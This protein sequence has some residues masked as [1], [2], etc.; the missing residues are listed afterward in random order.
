MFI[1]RTDHLRTQVYDVLRRERVLILAAIDVDSA[2]ACKIFQN[3]LCCDG[4]Q[5]SLVPVSGRQSLK[6]A[7]QEHAGQARHVVL[8]NC[9]ATISVVD[10]LDANDETHFYIFDS[11]RPFDLYNV[12]SD[13][14]HL[15]KLPDEDLDFPQPEEVFSDPE[16]E[17][18]DS[19]GEV[20]DTYEDSLEPE[21]D[22][23]GEPSAKRRAFTMKRKAQR[24]R[25]KRVWEQ[26]RA[27]ILFKYFEFYYHSSATSLIMLELAHFMSKDNNDLVWW[28]I[29]GLTE[30]LLYQRID[31]EKYV[32]DAAQLQ[33][34]FVLRLNN[35]SVSSVH[36][37]RIQFDQEL[38]LALYRH[39]SMYE[40]LLHSE[41][42]S[43]NFKVWTQHGQK[44]LHEFLANMG[45]P[46]VQ[47]KQKFGAMD[48]D[49]RNNVKTWMEELSPKYRLDDMTYGS[50]VAQ[51]G[52]QHKFSA[53]DVV[54]ALT[55]LLENT[56]GQMD[57]STNFFKA[58]DALSRTNSDVLR[59]GIALGLEHQLA[60]SQQV[61]LFMDMKQIVSAGSFTY[62]YIDESSPHYRYFSNTVLLTRLARYL[63]PTTRKRSQQLPFLLSAP[64]R[65]TPQTCV[66][67]GVPAVREAAHKN[68]LSRAFEAAVRHMKGAVNI[69]FDSFEPAVVQMR[70]E[71]RP[72]F[73]DAL[74]A[75]LES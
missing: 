41:Y 3:L 4:I 62:T 21:E 36:T 67:L 1:E 32:T 31:R 50:F 59:K 58:L 10:E 30:Q 69:E 43:V 47:S 45:L 44:L 66:V 39:W 73:F 46:L 27:D 60:L 65:G 42:S 5:Y 54:H 28:A 14:V 57:Y 33:E 75:V 52:Y 48:K 22:D 24:R 11:H 29:A 51:F 74:T 53:A 9:G 8:V 35:P 26:K 56:D 63:Q 40:S 23:V 55:G 25:E 18:E 49:I 2:C 34:K 64:A 15:V 70:Y 17:D 71:D 12:Y 72:R 37:L 16:E 61:R 20:A 13:K 7:F 68:Y 38:R 6:Q 19:D